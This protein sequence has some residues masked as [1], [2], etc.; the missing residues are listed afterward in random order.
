MKK[1]SITLLALSL[2]LSL[3]IG[4]IACN[5]NDEKWIGFDTEFAEAVCEKL[6]VT[7]VFQEID[8]DNKE[9]E[10]KGKSIDCIWNGFT[11]N[12]E[13]KAELTFS[14]SYMMN[15][16]AVII[17]KSNASKYTTL[18]SLKS[19]KLSAEAGSAGEDAIKED[20][21]L[22]QATYN[23]MQAQT[24]VLFEL[25]SGT[26]DAGVIDYVMAMAYVGKGDYA[27]LMII[28]DIELAYEEYAIGFRKNSD[29]AEK[30]NEIMLE[31][32]EDETLLNLGK[33]YDI[34]VQ[35]LDISKVDTPTYTNSVKD[36]E[37]IKEKGTL[38]IGITNF[39]PMNYKA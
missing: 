27:D 15:K 38:V 33:K 8:W 4:L 11:V 31:L 37:Y 14:K 34:D 22:K 9:I 35:L 17:K 13:R 23:S 10:L 21:F 5:K 24:D 32:Y 19:A 26:S 1:F 30:I 7:P 36:Y 18:E 39:K 20:D 12:D 25:I 16:Q 28:E 6:G 29:I 3:G 2:I